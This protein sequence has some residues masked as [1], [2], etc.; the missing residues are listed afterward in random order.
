M[1]ICTCGCS[2]EEHNNEIHGRMGKDTSCTK[3]P[4]KSFEDAKG[5]KRE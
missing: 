1:E 5:R 4:C 3:C 2:E